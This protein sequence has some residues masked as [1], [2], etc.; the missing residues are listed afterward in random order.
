VEDGKSLAH[1]VGESA[2]GDAG[3]LSPEVMVEGKVRARLDDDLAQHHRPARRALD[4]LAL[5]KGGAHRGG[6]A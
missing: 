6:P 2:C 3:N 1:G 5:G 4:V